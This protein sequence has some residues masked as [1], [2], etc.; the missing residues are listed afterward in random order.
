MYKCFS[1]GNLVCENCTG[2]PF[3]KRIIID[4]GTKEECS[5]CGKDGI[6]IPL[7]RLAEIVDEIFREYFEEGEEYPT[8][9][10][11]DSDDDHVYWKQY[12]ETPSEIIQEMA[13]IDEEI[14][15]DILDCF[16]PR[17][18]DDLCDQFYFGESNYSPK[19]FRSVTAKGIWEE[20]CYDIKH[21][22]R[23]FSNEAI[24][25]LNELFGEITEYKKY[26]GEGPIKTL[27]PENGISLFRGRIAE[28]PIDRLRIS[29]HP[30]S[31]LGPPP[32]VNARASRLNPAGI[33]IFYGAFK[34]ETC[35]A[36]LRP[37]VGS[38]VITGEFRIDT[39]IILLDMTILEDVYRN[40]S[41]FDP[42]YESKRDKLEFI[43]DFHNEIIQPVLPSDEA[44]NYL[45][46]QVFAAYL[47]DHFQPNIHGIIYGSSQAGPEQN[48]IALFRDIP[49]I[50]NNNSTSQN[51]TLR[52]EE[53]WLP[54]TTT[55]EAEV[56]L[57]FRFE[58]EEEYKRY[59]NE[60]EQTNGRNVNFCISYVKD[61]IR[62]HRI[63]SVSYQAP[64]GNV[65]IYPPE[66]FDF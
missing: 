15:N 12:G 54:D 64:S 28:Q 23:F 31:E 47:K 51:T 36:E 1:E 34:R 21:N 66:K 32:P 61:S 3:L 29:M 40:L 11:D 44:I 35:V 53:H 18:K 30:L 60:T 25:V 9:N 6:C 65:D 57:Y 26:N 8:S 16:A 41:Y 39:P 24:K 17:C 27:K 42:E 20:Y 49:L 14:A 5:Y 19:D 46:T 55:E 38:S 37:F 48:N 7:K 4:E 13:E 2:D 22:K 63:N 43:R 45:P 58:N 62:I 52:A 59:I 10:P 56:N 33:S 50:L